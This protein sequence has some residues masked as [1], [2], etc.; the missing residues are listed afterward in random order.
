MSC[1]TVSDA[2]WMGET[3]LTESRV[4]RRETA[5]QLKFSFVG[6]VQKEILGFWMPM[7]TCA[8]R[9]QSCRRHQR[10]L[11][12]SRFLSMDQAGSW[13]AEEREAHMRASMDHSQGLRRVGGAEAGMGDVDENTEVTSEDADLVAMRKAMKEYHDYVE[14]DSD[15][16]KMS[17]PLQAL[18][19]HMHSYATRYNV[20]LYRSLKENGGR[21]SKDGDGAMSKVKFQSVLLSVFG[22]MNEMFKPHLLDEPTTLYGTG[23]VEKGEVNAK[24]AQASAYAGRLTGAPAFDPTAA[25]QN[26]MEVKWI[27]FANDVGE[28]YMTYPPRGHGNELGK[29][30]N[31][32]TEIPE[33]H[34]Y[35]E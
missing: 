5:H 22:R 7:E 27:R 35:A 32:D 6:W 30:A 1:V 18:M 8:R 28:A 33:G 31:Y 19:R 29:M 4:L 20:D 24:K 25:A 12:S 10:S 21:Q 23:P 15:T 3:A 11:L 13:S 34:L 2:R 14:A 17:E 16:S 9:N 26:F